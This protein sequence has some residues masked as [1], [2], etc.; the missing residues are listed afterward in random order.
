MDHLEFWA[1][2]GATDSI[3]LDSCRMFFLL[4]IA[5][6]AQDEGWLRGISS[7]SQGPPTFQPQRVRH[8][9][10]ADSKCLV[11]GRPDLLCFCSLPS[12]PGTL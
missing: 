1:V 3:H 12:S 9:P 2:L 4:V 6:L 7:D 10:R 5:I 11:Q 8:S